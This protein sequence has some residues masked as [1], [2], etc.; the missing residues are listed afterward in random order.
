MKQQAITMDAHPCF[1]D[2]ATLN[3][4]PHARLAELRPITPL[5]QFGPNQYLVLRAPHVELLLTD[6]RTRQVEGSE[7][8]ALKQIPDGITARFISDLFL[9][10]NG[11]MHRKKRGLFARSFSHRAMQD[12][13]GQ[14]R[15]V[16]DGIVANLP[17]GESIDF[18]DRV[19]ARVPADMIAAILGLP[20]DDT[21]HFSRLVYDV[22]LAFAPVY[23]HDQHDKIENATK[24]LFHYVKGQLRL[25]MAASSDDM[26][27]DLVTDWQVQQ[28][29]PFNSLAFQVVGLIIAGSDTTRTAF[30]M[31]IA[32]LLERPTDWAALRFDPALIPGA[33]SE[34]M[35]YEPSVATIPRL[36][37]APLEL[38]GNEVPAGVALSLSTMSAMRDPAVYVNPEQFDIRR[39]DH[40]RFHPVFGIGPH[41]CIGEMLA[42]IEME[43]SLAAILDGAPEIE[44]QTRP[45]MMGFGGIRQI[46][47]MKVRIP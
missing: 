13:R 44:L 39:T 30:A 15:S 18:V 33:V 2:P 46:T 36:T 42:R 16:A 21:K 17:R 14:V 40:S 6:P 22:S 29:I 8:V 9:F 23:P 7:F 45:R 24:D 32:M 38:D 4:A 27:S 5:V 35:R 3:D 37:T 1:V 43:E 41:R 47:P 12:L 34:G 28:D 11:G 19:A 26:L 10:S 31:L 25:R 20:E